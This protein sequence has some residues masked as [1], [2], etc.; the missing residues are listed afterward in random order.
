MKMQFHTFLKTFIHSF[1]CK[2]RNRLNTGNRRKGQ[3]VFKGIHTRHSLYFIKL[4][5]FK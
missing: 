5:F 1:F 2:V 4:S 3:I